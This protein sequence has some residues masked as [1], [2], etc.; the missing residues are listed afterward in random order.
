[1]EYPKK[2]RCIKAVTSFYTE[3]KIYNVDNY[4]RVMNNEGIGMTRVCCTNTLNPNVYDRFNMNSDFELV[5]EIELDM[6]TPT[7]RLDYAK[8]HYP[9]GTKY[10]P[11]DSYGHPYHGEYNSIYEPKLW[12]DNDIEAGS[13]LIYHNGKWAEIIAVIL[14]IIVEIASAFL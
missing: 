13:G 12:N 1:M 8:K 7:G 14:E 4:G 11:I 2:V 3:G 9:I 5:E 10:R 6:L